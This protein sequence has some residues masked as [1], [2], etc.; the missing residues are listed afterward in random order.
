MS[1]TAIM[2]RCHYEGFSCLADFAVVYMEDVDA[3]N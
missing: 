3:Y 1:T 2:G